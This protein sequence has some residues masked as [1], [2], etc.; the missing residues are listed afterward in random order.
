MNLLYFEE[1]YFSSGGLTQKDLSKSQSIHCFFCARSVSRIKKSTAL[2]NVI[3]KLNSVGC[4]G[5]HTCDGNDRV[6]ENNEKLFLSRHFELIESGKVF[7]FR[8]ELFRIL[9]RQQ[10][11]FVSLYAKKSCGKSKEFSLTMSK[12]FKTCWAVRPENCF[13]QWS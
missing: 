3:F 13:S 1:W 5:K 8:W 4:T 6:G 9:A 2:S 11:N 12:Y 10:I 7:T